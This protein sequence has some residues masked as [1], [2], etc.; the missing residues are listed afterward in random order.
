MI[1]FCLL[2]LTFVFGVMRSLSHFHILFLAFLYW[3]IIGGNIG[4]GYMRLTPYGSF[5]FLSGGVFLL[6]GKG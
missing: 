3:F 2:S 1:G 4:Y 6:A 5:V